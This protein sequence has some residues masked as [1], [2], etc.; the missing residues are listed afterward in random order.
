M[1]FQRQQFS[2]QCFEG[3]IFFSQGLQFFFRHGCTLVGF[4]CFGRS[5]GDLSS[6]KYCQ[7]YKNYCYYCSVHEI[8]P[9]TRSSYLVCTAQAESAFNSSCIFSLVC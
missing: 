7:N 1:L 6:Y 9:P 2:Y 4:L 5:V 3:S 8:F